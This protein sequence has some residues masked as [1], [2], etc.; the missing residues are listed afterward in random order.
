MTVQTLPSW[1]ELGISAPDEL[2]ELVAASLGLERIE[3]S[4][5]IMD[6]VPY[7]LM[8]LTTRGRYRVHGTATIGDRQLP[9]SIFVK[10][11]QSWTLTEVFQALPLELRQIASAGLPWEVEPLAYRSTLSTA[12]PPGLRMPTAYAV[13]DLGPL[14]TAIWMEDIPVVEATW[15]LPRY[16]ATA[17]LLGRF[18]SRTAVADAIS[19]LAD[20]VAGASVRDYVHGRVTHQLFPL[21]RG[22]EVWQHPLVARHFADLQDPLRL[23]ADQLPDLADELTELPSGVCHG[24]ACTR[25]LLVTPTGETVLI[26]FGFLRPAPLAVDLAQLAFGGIQLG[27]RGYSDVPDLWASCLDGYRAG[28][29]LE[30]RSASETDLRRAAILGAAIFT[31]ISAIPV[32]YLDS[33][34]DP[35]VEQVF[36][37]RATVARFILEE[38]RR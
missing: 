36:E 35:Q 24:D 7:D 5:L 17:T 16:A 31:A 28:V 9:V 34:A 29:L 4:D 26:D 6:E 19:S 15:D 38:L 8:A 18:A 22:D 37:G 30:G 13:R 20:V 1:A 2:S 10:V 11:V 14:A 21:I 12:L 23:L 33:A 32:E 25:N 27:E 3:V